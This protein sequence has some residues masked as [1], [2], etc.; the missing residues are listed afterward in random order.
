MAAPCALEGRFGLLNVADLPFTS[1]V[2]LF[3]PNAQRESN[4]QD[5]SLRHRVEHGIDRL[6]QGGRCIL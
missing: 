4:G 3:R 6:S 1:L 2:W 5:S